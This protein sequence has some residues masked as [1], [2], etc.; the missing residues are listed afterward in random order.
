MSEKLKSEIKAF[1]YY[2]TLGACLT[3]YAHQNFS[4]KEELKDIK[5]DIKTIDKRV[6]EIHKFL[7]PKE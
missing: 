3:I 7:K 4:T 5:E 6:Y 2:F 1:L